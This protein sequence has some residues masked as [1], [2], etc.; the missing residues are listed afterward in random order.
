[1]LY[2]NLLCKR[3]TT[4][5]SV[6]V[7]AIRRQITIM[8]TMKIGT[9]VYDV[10]TTLAD[11]YRAAFI[12]SSINRDYIQSSIDRDYIQPR[13]QARIARAKLARKNK[14]NNSSSVWR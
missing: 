8:H 10:H 2:A 5:Q 12:Q 13:L 9:N 4:V 6:K 11:F 1:M 14:K 7:L 3:D